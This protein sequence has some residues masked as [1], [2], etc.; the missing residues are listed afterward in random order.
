MV[1]DNAKFINEVEKIDND[2]SIYTGSFTLING[3][4]EI[5]N[6]GS[7]NTTP[8]NLESEYIFEYLYRFGG[9][10]VREGDTIYISSSEYVSAGYYEKERGIWGTEKKYYD[11]LD[12]QKELNELQLGFN[13]IRKAKPILRKLWLII[14]L[15]SLI[16]LILN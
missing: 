4:G 2:T 11:F 15:I 6:R 9:D 13:K 1:G 10:T 16:N 12:E 3:Y 5:S 8:M 7:N 14:Q